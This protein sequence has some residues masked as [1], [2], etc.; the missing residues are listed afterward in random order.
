MEKFYILLFI[1]HKMA[2]EWGIFSW[3]SIFVLSI[4][5]IGIWV[6]IEVKRFKHKI[7]AILL[8]VLVIFSYVSFAVVAQDNELNFTSISG[9]VEATKIY[10]AWIGSILGN[11]KTI[12]ANVFKLDWSANKIT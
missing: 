10:F 6:V 2:L 3:T 5:T 11:L 1:L 9:V 4:I 7:F 12:T 8:I